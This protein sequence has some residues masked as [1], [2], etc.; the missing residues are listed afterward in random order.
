MTEFL[1]KFNRRP[2][3]QE[4]SKTEYRKIP[5]EYPY[6]ILLEEIPLKEDG[7]DIPGFISVEGAPGKDEF[8]VDYVRGILKFNSQNAGNEVSITYTG[9]GSLVRAEDINLIQKSINNIEETIEKTYFKTYTYQE[10]LEL[11]NKKVGETFFAT[12]TKHF[13]GWTGTT[14]IDFG[15]E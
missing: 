7:V 6:H 8:E 2:V 9:I 5:L 13:Y 11:E 12:D 3:G 14:L 1:E 10:I 4:V 15:G